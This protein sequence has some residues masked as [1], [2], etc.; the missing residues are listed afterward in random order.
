MTSQAQELTNR[1]LAKVNGKVITSFDVVKLTRVDER[2]ITQTLPPGQRESAINELRKRALDHLIDNELILK[3]F[4]DKQYKVPQT[5]LE[6]RLEKIIAQQANG[7][8]IKFNQKL[9]STKLTLAEY[10][11]KLEESI[12][13]EMLLNEMVKRKVIVNDSD[14]NNYYKE[15]E[16]AFSSKGAYNLQIIMLKSDNKDAPAI[17]EI[18]VALKDGKDFTDLANKYNEGTGLPEGGR[19]GKLIEEDLRSEFLEAVKKL[20]NGETAGPIFL[21]GKTYFLH[22]IQKVGAEVQALDEDLKTRIRRRLE[23]QQEDK[24]YDE[25]MNDLRQR[26]AIEE[27]L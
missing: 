21:E 26:S 13:V 4:K 3:E 12:S 27:Y 10:R 23:Q 24:I 11:A 18:Q 14:I 5:Y 7:D 25:F 9:R 8:R 2:K 15:N 6:T 19:L 20:N 22:L 17:N 1:I 16:N